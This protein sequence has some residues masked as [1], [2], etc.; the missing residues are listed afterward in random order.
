MTYNQ[1][2]STV[3]ELVVTTAAL[4]IYDEIADGK[5]CYTLLLHIVLTICLLIG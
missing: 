1:I 3:N 5:L 4:R 2:R